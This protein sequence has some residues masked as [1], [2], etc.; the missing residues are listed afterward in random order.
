MLSEPG[1][2]FEGGEFETLEADGTFA[3]PTF[4]QGDALVF[5]SEAAA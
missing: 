5:C 4:C 3:R 1:V 2:D